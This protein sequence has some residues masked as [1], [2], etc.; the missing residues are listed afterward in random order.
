MTR[1]LRL[2]ALVLWGFNAQAF[3]VE[4]NSNGDPLRWHLDPPDPSVDTNVVNPN[5]KA[6]RFFLA[7]DAYSTTNTAAELNAV[8]ASFA[9]WQSIS[10]TVLKFED[11]G[12]VSPQVDVNTSDN[13]NVVFWTRRTDLLVNGQMD[14]ISGALGVTF[15]SYFPDNNAQAE[16]DIVFN[17]AQYTWSTD[18]N[19][20]DATRQFVEGT[21]THEIGHFLGL[22][23]SPVGGATMLFHGGGGVNVQAGLSSDEVAAA[24]WLYGTASTLATL[25]QFQGRVT[26]N[27]SSV[28]G[29][30][31]LAEESAS[32]NLAAGT[33]TRADGSYVLPALP[34][35]QYNVRVTPLDVASANVFLI[36][37]RDIASSYDSAA[38]GFLPSANLATTLNAGVSV[39]VDFAVTAGSPAFR[40]TQIRQVSATSGSFRW[41]SLPAAI[42][43]GQ[44]NYFIGVGSAELPTNGATLAITGDG[45]TLGPAS[46]ATLS[47]LNFISVSISVASNATP[48]LRSFIVQRGADL[49]YAN[50]FLEVASTIPDFNFDGLDDRFQRRYFPLFTAPEAGPDADPDGDGLNNQAEFVAGTDPTHSLSVLKIDQVVLNGQ[51]ST[52]T[53][54]SVANRRYQVFSRVDLENAPWQAIG[55]PVTAG[56]STAEFKDVSATNGFRFYRI[57]VL[58]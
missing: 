25:G 44:S 49:A 2:A 39:R 11:G 46:F 16:A 45:L 37:G 15:N 9:Q 1:T 23:H 8:R 43:P 58:P 26:M 21:A 57:Q 54:Q 36:R 40:I 31:V 18:F 5:T 27:G 10:G 56:G 28:F 51:G 53:W 33:V 13:Q 19:S 17:G 42:R 20:A 7:S 30:A 22:K 50:G 41:S 6:I 35:G 48:G 3:V 34:P 38:T 12:L 55:S 29:A 4:L 52:V 24:K 32:G 47:G 14:N